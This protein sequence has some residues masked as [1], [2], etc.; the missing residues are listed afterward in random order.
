MVMRKIAAEAFLDGVADELQKAGMAMDLGALKNFLAHALDA[1]HLPRYRGMDPAKVLQAPLSKLKEVKPLTE[2]AGKPFVLK[3]KS[4]SK[5]VGQIDQRGL[6]V[7]KSYYGP[8]N[9]HDKLRTDVDI[10]KLVDPKG[11]L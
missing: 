8:G 5:I 4:G 2:H 7:P 6:V 3:T 9:P 10:S 11:E 1:R